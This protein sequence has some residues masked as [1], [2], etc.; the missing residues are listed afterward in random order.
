MAPGLELLPKTTALPTKAANAI[1]NAVYGRDSD[2]KFE[3]AEKHQRVLNVFRA[4][5]A[6]LVQQYGDGHPGYAS[7]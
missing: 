6:D 7:Y 1:N 2:V 4:F 5:I 3:S